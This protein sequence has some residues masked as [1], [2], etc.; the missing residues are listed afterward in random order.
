MRRR[1]LTIAI[2][3]LAGAVVNVAV[4]WGCI[5]WAPVSWHVRTGPD[6][7]PAPPPE[8]WTG[9]VIGGKSGGPG[10]DIFDARSG[11]VTAPRVFASLA[12]DRYRAGWPSRSLYA[13]HLV[14][15]LWRRPDW[16][17][18]MSLTSMNQFDAAG[19]QV[20]A[21]PRMD[22]W[23]G[24]LKVTFSWPKPRAQRPLPLLPVWPGF[25]VNTFSYATFLWLLTCLV[26]AVRRFL[27]LRRGLC[28]ACGYDLRHA[29]HEACPECG[30]TA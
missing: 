25:A 11:R 17:C 4:A 18:G 12:M 8:W 15:R 23:R 10:W 1:L 14:S 5:L 30:V 24:R 28:A 2:F 21:D 7:W 29:E 3:L 9:H 20:P 16:A 27:R 13:V 26:I 22:A 6:Q 19:Y